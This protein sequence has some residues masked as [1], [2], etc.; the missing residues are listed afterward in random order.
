MSSRTTRATQVDPRAARYLTQ[1]VRYPLPSKHLHREHDIGHAGA[2][3]RAH[4][5]RPCREYR[6]AHAGT[7]PLERR[8]VPGAKPAYCG[9]SHAPCVTLLAA[10]SK[11]RIARAR[12]LVARDALMVR[13][14]RLARRQGS[15]ALAASPP[16]APAVLASRAQRRW[17]RESPP[18]CHDRW[19]AAARVTR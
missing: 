11:R 9:T 2:V 4:P 17:H 18:R 7:P 10:D 3:K 15:G 1:V 12:R 13:P 19:S 5:P 14:C 16:L 6:A 8:A